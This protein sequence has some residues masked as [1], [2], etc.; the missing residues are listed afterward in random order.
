MRAHAGVQVRC[1]V[2]FRVGVRLRMMCMAPVNIMVRFC[3]RWL[4]VLKH[5]HCS[6]LPGGL[7]DEH[8]GGCGSCLVFET[9]GEP[10]LWTTLWLSLRNRF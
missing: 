8:V 10:P 2:T 3:P 1:S 7:I 5:Q 6:G 4:Q 9:Q